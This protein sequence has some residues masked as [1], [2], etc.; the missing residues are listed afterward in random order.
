MSTQIGLQ[1]DNLLNL[2]LVSMEQSFH[3]MLGY[4]TNTSNL[5]Q[6]SYTPKKIQTNKQN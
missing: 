2:P 6:P 1:Q 3:H 4:G 5:Q